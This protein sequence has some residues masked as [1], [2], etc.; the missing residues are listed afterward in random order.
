MLF[1]RR[2]LASS[3]ALRLWARS[4]ATRL[5]YISINVNVNDDIKLYGNAMALKCGHEKV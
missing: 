3:L 5:E 2:A 4:I 1:Y